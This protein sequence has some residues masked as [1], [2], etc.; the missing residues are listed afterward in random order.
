MVNV[1]NARRSFWALLILC[2]VFTVVCHFQCHVM[3]QSCFPKF[4]GLNGTCR[5]HLLQTIR[6]LLDAGASRGVTR[7]PE[8][9]RREATWLLWHW[10]FVKSF[11][12]FVQPLWVFDKDFGHEVQRVTSLPTLK[13]ER[14]MLGGAG[15]LSLWSLYSR[16]QTSSGIILQTLGYTAVSL[17]KKCTATATATCW[18]IDTGS[19]AEQRFAGR[20]NQ[21]GERWKGWPKQCFFKTGTGRLYCFFAFDAVVS[22]VITDD[23][24]RED[25]TGAGMPIRATFQHYSKKMKNRLTN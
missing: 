12:P 3:N 18:F 22:G 24:W 14:L 9:Q 5:L 2:S 11:L 16:I 13:A 7:L 8:V 20:G 25:N 6:L 1:S 15:S 23:Q 19:H 10:Q 21:G 4:N 17:V